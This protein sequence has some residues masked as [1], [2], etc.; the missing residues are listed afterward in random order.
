MPFPQLLLSYG[1]DVN[2][3]TA[4]GATP[5]HR[6]AYQNHRGVVEKLLAAGAKPQMQVN[7]PG[8]L[9]LR[10]FAFYKVALI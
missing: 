2:A 4:G 10:A 1:A 3:T 6:A 5:L 7:S 8:L 9:G